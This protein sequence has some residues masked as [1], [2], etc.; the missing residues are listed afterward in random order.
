MRPVAGYPL[1][2]G[3]A[4]DLRDPAGLHAAGVLAVVDLA[5]DEPPA[6]VPRD[7]VYCRF[8]LIDGGGNPPW[9]L[10][11][12]VSA[13]ADLLRSAVPTLV[14]CGAGMSRTPAVA[15]A[16]I[17]LISGRP[18]EAALADLVRCGPADVSPTLWA[19]VVASHS[20]LVAG[21]CR[22]KAPG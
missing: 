6:R 17:T 2:L 9:L 11:S 20:R 21:I 4:G 7:L 16:A 13:V 5:L 1:W 22:E 12:A 8:P 10:R 19:D 3:H 14:C 18:P 15:A